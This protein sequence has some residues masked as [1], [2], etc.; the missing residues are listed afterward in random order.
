MREPIICTWFSHPVLTSRPT[1]AWG[2]FP[3][4]RLPSSSIIPRRDFWLLTLKTLRSPRLSLILS[5]TFRRMKL[6]P[7][8][9]KPPEKSCR[10]HLKSCAHSKDNF[11]FNKSLLNNKQTGLPF[12]NGR[13][14]CLSIQFKHSFAA[15]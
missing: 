14:V 7:F 8:R 5:S 13:P 6:S 2:R 11:D 9:R 12:Y 3:H 15:R 1:F 4:R 10:K